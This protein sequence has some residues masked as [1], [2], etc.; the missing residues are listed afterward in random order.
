[1]NFSYLLVDIQKTSEKHHLVIFY[2][3]NNV[4]AINCHLFMQSAANCAPEA[5]H[6]NRQILREYQSCDL[7]L[8]KETIKC[9]IQ[10]TEEDSELLE[11]NV[12]LNITKMFIS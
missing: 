3:L 6:I 4:Y 11:E 10:M 2:G 1:M 12:S 8:G 9:N 7:A 5:L